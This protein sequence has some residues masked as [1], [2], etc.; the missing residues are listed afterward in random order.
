[1]LWKRSTHSLGAQGHDLGDDRV[2]SLATTRAAS[3]EK[4]VPNPS[5][6]PSVVSSIYSTFI[7]AALDQAT[8]VL[9]TAALSDGRCRHLLNTR[10]GGT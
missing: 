4:R 5:P 7:G 1:M 6:T 8:A 9:G 2:T 10:E 3:R